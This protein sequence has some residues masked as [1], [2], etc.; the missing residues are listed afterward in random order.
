MT[1]NPTVSVR[2]FTRTKKAVLAIALSCAAALAAGCSE[3]P[4][5]TQDDA[6]PTR[7]S[8]PTKKSDSGK[9]EDTTSSVKIDDKIVQA[10]GDMPSAPFAFD[11][12]DVSPE[13][14]NV[15]DAVARCFITGKLAGRGLKLIG[16][17]DPR[18]ETEYNLALGQR[19][20]GS[21]QGF[22]A[23]KGLDN[24]KMASSSKGE[25]EATGT[26]EAGWAKDRRVDI[27]LA[28]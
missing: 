24:G 28:D 7:A 19:R 5:K 23:K 15:L 25:F 9:G 21:I 27:L 26:D 20:A 16:H 1:S 14:A 8:T 10:C 2:S 12:A 18:G 6:Q 11:S 4:P 22:L 3:E 17:A 13:A